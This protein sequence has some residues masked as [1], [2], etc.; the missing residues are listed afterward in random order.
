M[1]NVRL[2]LFLFII[3]FF[4]RLFHYISNLYYFS[5]II[6][7]NVCPCRLESHHTYLYTYIYNI[8]SLNSPV[9]II[10]IIV[11]VC[12]ITNQYPLGSFYYIAFHM[13]SVIAVAVAAI[14]VV[15]DFIFLSCHLQVKSLFT[16]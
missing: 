6:L 4:V 15:A 2:L 1:E 12:F 3:T 10:I 11:I 8:C 9:F 5:I 16:K 14:D 7:W 13:S